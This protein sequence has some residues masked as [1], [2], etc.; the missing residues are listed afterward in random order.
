MQQLWLDL[1]PAGKTVA[2]ATAISVVVSNALFGVITQS[3]TY[4]FI[5]FLFSV[6]IGLVAIYDVNCVLTGQCTVWGWIKSALIIVQYLAFMGF[7]SYV[8][9]QE[10]RKRRTRDEKEAYTPSLKFSRS[11]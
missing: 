6:I 5:S 8:I 3:I 4:T 2:I 9:Y 1:T 10:R 7:T 11:L